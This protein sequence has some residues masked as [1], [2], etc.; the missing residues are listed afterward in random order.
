[1][2]IHDGPVADDLKRYQVEGGQQI[3][4]VREFKKMALL[5]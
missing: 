3:V 4:R 5:D 1:M 2:P